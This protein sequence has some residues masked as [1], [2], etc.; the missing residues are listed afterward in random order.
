[1]Y[2]SAVLGAVLLAVLGCGP[3]SAQLGQSA[4]FHLIAANS[5]NATVIKSR[6]GIVTS[7]QLG[8]VGSAPA[9]LKFYDKATAPTCGTDIPTKVLIIP[10][11]STAANGGGSNITISLGVAFNIGIGICVVVGIADADNTAVPAA[12]YVINID[13]Q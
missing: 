11:A 13:W 9:Y 2:R 5:N 10:A 8:G 7:V 12:T 6:S 1:M 4:Q 3:S